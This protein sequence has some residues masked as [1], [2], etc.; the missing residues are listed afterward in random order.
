MKQEDV[1]GWELVRVLEKVASDAHLLREFFIDLLTPREYR[2]LGIRWQIVKQ[3]HR[4][5]PQRT[6]A[7]NLKVSVGTITRGSRELLDE[8][9]GFQQVL[10]KLYGN[11][12]K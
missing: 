3:L 5:V 7:K 9:G 6:I 8:N 2:E 11:R 10:R 1:Y 4:G 12:S